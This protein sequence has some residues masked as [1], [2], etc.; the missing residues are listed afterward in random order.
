[1]VDTTFHEYVLAYMSMRKIPKFVYLTSTQYEDVKNSAA[2]AWV[3]EQQVPVYVDYEQIN[4]DV[5]DS[6]Y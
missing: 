3:L 4:P 2:L 1:M 5:P 6:I